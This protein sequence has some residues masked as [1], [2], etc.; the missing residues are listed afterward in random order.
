M[1]HGLT[2][3]CLIIIHDDGDISCSVAVNSTSISE[4]ASKTPPPTA[5]APVLEVG[6]ISEGVRSAVAFGDPPP[7][8]DGDVRCW[9]AVRRECGEGSADGGGDWRQS[10]TVWRV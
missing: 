1:P 5:A 7:R 6:D 3:L 4:A 2:R 9:E 8:F 10:M